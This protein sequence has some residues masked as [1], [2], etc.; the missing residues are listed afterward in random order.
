M[1][2]FVLKQLEIS[3]KLPK[4]VQVDPGYLSPNFP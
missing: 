3:K 2:C 4:D 1:L